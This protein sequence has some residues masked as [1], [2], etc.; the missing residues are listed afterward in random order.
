[1]VCINGWEKF[2]YPC[3]QANRF[4]DVRL[5]LNR[6]HTQDMPAEVREMVARLIDPDDTPY[7]LTKRGTN[8]HA[9]LDDPFFDTYRTASLVPTEQPSQV[10]ILGVR[11]SHVVV[12]FL[13]NPV[14]AQILKYACGGGTA[15]TSETQHCAVCRHECGT[16]MLR[17][18][19]T[20]NLCGR[21]CYEFKYVFG[22]K[23]VY[24]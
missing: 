7:K 9:A 19:E 22:E 11:D 24:R 1:L 12:S 21:A 20:E 5:L 8:A 4:I 14:E 3:S 16:T 10:E 17:V 6:L 2:G 15:T 13:A 18:G 23:T